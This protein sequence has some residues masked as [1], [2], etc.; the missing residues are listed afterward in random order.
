MG[1]LKRQFLVDEGE[2]RRRSSFP[3]P[4]TR[5]SLKTCMTSPSSLSV[6]KKNLLISRK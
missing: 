1:A 5:S 4:S 2:K 3:L 6:G